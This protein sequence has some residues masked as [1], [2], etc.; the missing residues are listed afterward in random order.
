[1]ECA[2]TDYGFRWFYLLYPF[3]PSWLIVKSLALLL[4]HIAYSSFEHD[5]SNL[6]SVYTEDRSNRIAF[7]ILLLFLIGLFVYLY[8]SQAVQIN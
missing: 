6:A 8:F 5:D 3:I 1:M 4:W 7:L 2:K